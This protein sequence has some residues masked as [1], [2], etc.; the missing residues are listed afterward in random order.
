[1]RSNVVLV[2]I[3][4][5]QPIELG[6]HQNLRSLGS[7]ARPGSA[8][9]PSWLQSKGVTVPLAPF[10]QAMDVSTCSSSSSGVF[11]AGKRVFGTE[12]HPAAATKRAVATAGPANDLMFMA[13]TASLPAVS[14]RASGAIGLLELLGLF[15]C[16]NSY[17]CS[18]D[19]QCTQNNNK[20]ASS[21]EEFV[22]AGHGFGLAVGS[23]RTSSPSAAVMVPR[24]PQMG[25]SAKPAI[26]R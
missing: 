16:L 13:S 25:G 18:D 2:A 26:P 17:W 6:F 7:G 19:C 14:H 10:S 24:F 8:P 20:A 23:A 4:I 15:V 3:P 12:L 22:G 21:G 5:D 1:M 11:S 9:S